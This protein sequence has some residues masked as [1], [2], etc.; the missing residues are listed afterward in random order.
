[1]KRLLA[2]GGAAVA[3]SAT[4]LAGW[5]AGHRAV[6][7]H[8]EVYRAHWAEREGADEGALHYL[9]LGDSAAQGVGASEVAKGYVSLLG[10][11]LS[12]ETGR[13]VVVTNL[14][15]TGAKAGDVV[16]DQLP[17][18]AEL[19]TPDLVTLDI[20]GN[21][22]VF[23]GHNPQTYAESMEIILAALPEGSFIADVP[24]FSLPFWGRQS[25][26]MSEFAADAVE[27]HG[28]HLV[29][30]HA[31]TRGVGLRYH[32]YTASDL[33]HPND[34]AYQGWADL[35]WEQIEASGRLATIGSAGRR[36]GN[37]TS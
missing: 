3:A 9:A 1:M 10:Q 36:P 25:R 28:H 29:G 30:L 18:L 5:Y 19:P 24:W 22:V 11:R 16:R 2:A 12:E 34:V 14:S 7:R 27:R 6:R 21:D 31:L 32:L 35:F 13:P 17:Q 20:G 37:V 26:L 4:A 15:V 23:P 33:F 8:V